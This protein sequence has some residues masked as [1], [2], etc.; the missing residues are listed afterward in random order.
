[1]GKYVI[2]SDEDIC[3][4]FEQYSKAGVE[5]IDI[6]VEFLPLDMVIYHFCHC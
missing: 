3:H 5:N 2:D 6:F 4:V 1:M